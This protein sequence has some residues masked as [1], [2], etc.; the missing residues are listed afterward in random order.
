MKTLL[1]FFSDSILL[2]LLFALVSGAFLVTY[3]LSPIRYEN[4]SFA[5]E[6]M[7]DVSVLGDLDETNVVYEDIFSNSDE[8][9]C[10]SSTEDQAY[11]AEIHVKKLKA[12][13]SLEKSI[14]SISNN[15]RHN[16]NLHLQLKKGLNAQDV[17]TEI[18][19]NGDKFSQDLNNLDISLLTG[20]DYEISLALQSDVQINFPLE[21][22]LVV[23]R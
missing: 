9:E 3:A 2:V 8:F 5:Q 6:D 14:V 18:L 10:I 23:S 1:S 12:K 13:E 4:S 22:E 16:V 15:S 19:I 21:M 17:K 7:V 20:T 11:F